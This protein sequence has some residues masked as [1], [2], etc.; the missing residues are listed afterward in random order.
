[1]KTNLEAF[2]AKVGPFGYRPPLAVHP[3][4]H[5]EAEL[6]IEN[7]RHDVALLLVAVGVE[8]IRR[9]AVPNLNH[10]VKRVIPASWPTRARPTPRASF[11]EEQIDCLRAE[12]LISIG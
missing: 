11:L 10:F 1:M 4:R 3:V 5:H 12:L 7:I 6:A 9:A 8:R 2:E